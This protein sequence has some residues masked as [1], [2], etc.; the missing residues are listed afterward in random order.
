MNPDIKAQLRVRKLSQLIDDFHEGMIQVP[1]YHRGFVWD[2]QQRLGLLD[3]IKNGYPIGMFIFQYIYSDPHGF[4]FNSQKKI[5]TYFV[6]L[7]VDNFYYI[8]DGYQRIST[9]LSCLINPVRT[10]LKR[11]E[12]EWKVKFN[13]IYDLQKECFEFST[14]EKVLEIYKI[15]VYKFL[16]GRE[17]YAFRRQMELSNLSNDKIFNYTRQYENLSARFGECQIPCLEVS[18]GDIT[19]AIEIFSRINLPAANV[20]DVW[21]VSA[22][23]LNPERQFSL[24]E[25]IDQLRKELAQYHFKGLNKRTV[26]LCILNALRK[27]FTIRFNPAQLADLARR[28]DFVDITRNTLYNIKKAVQFLYDELYV[29][30]YKFLPYDEQLVYITSQLSTRA[31]LLGHE[32]DE[33]KRW[34]WVT[35]YSEEFN[36]SKESKN[37]PQDARIKISSFP[38]ELAKNTIRERV[39]ILFMFNNTSRLHYLLQSNYRLFF[40]FTDVENK[41]RTENIVLVLDHNLQGTCH[42]DVSIYS[43]LFAGNWDLDQYFIT[44]WMKDQY[45]ENHD[46][47]ALL[48]ARKYE[49]M[50]A[51]K[52]FV[53]ELGL[54]YEVTE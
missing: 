3:S 52:E 20:T 44:S 51:E 30:N 36:K 13:V 11:D 37:S 9:L 47:D 1:A 38:K 4:K 45:L 23:S 19:Q 18:G 5:G 40:L 46:R 25:E 54:I 49:I 50:K 15:P 29:L 31:E 22:L 12:K 35:S 39:L 27:E 48:N 32:R 26:L 14:E 34:F 41:W 42:A 28:D 16:D 43:E 24:E 7:R 8:I 17:F 2:Q 10:Y 6:P 33:L 53:E 21:K